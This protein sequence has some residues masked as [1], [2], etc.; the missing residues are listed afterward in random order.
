MNAAVDI[1]VNG[2]GWTVDD[3]G[4]Y[5]DELG[6]NSEGAQELYDFV[7]DTPGIILPYGVGLTEFML[8]REK[9]ELETGE[10][11]NVVDYHR[12]LLDN[13][14]RPFEMVEKDV[15]D[16]ID[17]NYD[18]NHP[19]PTEP[20]TE[21]EILL[22]AFKVPLLI[23]AGVLALIVF[24]IIALVVHHKSKKKHETQ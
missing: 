8:L 5:L 1:G 7:I 18:P 15:Q 12:V 3:V 16:Y 20:P 19:E 2:L 14:P 6:L 21:Q 23:G 10:N 24:G 4:S 9:A 22:N 13:G 11:F 17:G